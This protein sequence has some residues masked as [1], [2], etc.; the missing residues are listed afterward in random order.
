MNRNEMLP[1]W[2]TIGETYL[3]T[4]R[5]WWRLALMG[6]PVIALLTY[7][8]WPLESPIFEGPIIIAP[9]DE[10]IS[11]RVWRNIKWGLSSHAIFAVPA[12]VGLVAIHRLALLGDH[13]SYPAL[14]FRLGK[15]EVR[16]VLV[17]TVAAAPIML[18]EAVGWGLAFAGDF[19]GIAPPRC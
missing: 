5:H 11:E 12:A 16:F 13:G 18:Y 17:L 19:E 6:L 7:L 2:K 4:L 15:R 8:A 9:I 10:S 1:V 3:F 14:P